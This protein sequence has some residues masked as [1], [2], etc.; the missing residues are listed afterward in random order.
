[1]EV[2]HSS[3]TWHKRKTEACDGH[4]GL[5]GGF[6]AMHI[7]LGL[8]QCPVGH[9]TH[10]NS[11]N[12]VIIRKELLTDMTPSMNG[13]KHVVPCIHDMFTPPTKMINVGSRGGFPGKA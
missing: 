13:E 12:V 11:R 7:R 6:P 5:G 4:V 1:M 2:G 9:T 10:M 3:L 8:G